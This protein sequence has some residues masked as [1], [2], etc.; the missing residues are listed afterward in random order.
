MNRRLFDFILLLIA[1][2]GVVPAWLT[3]IEVRRLTRE[4]ER[5][6]RMSQSLIVTDPAKIHLIAIDTGDPYHFA[7]RI[8][9]PANFQISLSSFGS[10][11]Q[12]KQ[13]ENLIQVRFIRNHYGQMCIF[14]NLLGNTYYMYNFERETAEMLRDHWNDVTVYRAGS[15]GS[16]VAGENGRLVLLRLTLSEDALRE[17]GPKLD[18]TSRGRLPLI[19]ETELNI[20]K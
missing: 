20:I 2:A 12:T 19:Y 4:H 16:V 10:F 5:F 14:T 11:I 3:G 1:I 13:G 9:T 8:Y 15:T 17:I 6:A 7:W 18:P